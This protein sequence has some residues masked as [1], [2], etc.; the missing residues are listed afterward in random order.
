MTRACHNCGVLEERRVVNGQ[1]RTNLEPFSQLCLECLSASV[2]TF[3]SRRDEPKTD[4]R[5]AAAG[6]DND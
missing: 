6:S 4:V 3:R 1:E 5:M 2:R